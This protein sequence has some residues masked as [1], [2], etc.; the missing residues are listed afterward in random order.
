MSLSEINGVVLTVRVA[1][2][3]SQSAIVGL[4]D[5][6]VKVR[7]AAAPVGGEANAELIKLLAKVFGVAKRD[8]EIVSGATAKTKRVR[9]KGACQAH[10]DA[11]LKGKT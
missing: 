2:R 8:V 4:Y 3:A 7:V 5:G 10:I 1:A 9:L 6:A 11:V